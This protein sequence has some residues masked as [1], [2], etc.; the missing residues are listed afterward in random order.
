VTVVLVL[1]VVGAALALWIP[2]LSFDYPLSVGLYEAEYRL[3]G[4]LDERYLYTVE[5]AGTYRMLY[6]GFDDPLVFNRT[7]APHIELIGIEPP[8][9]Y[10][11]YA[12]DTSGEVRVFGGD[13]PGV[14]AFVIARAEPNEVGVVETGYFNRGSYEARYRF[15]IRPPIEYDDTLVHVNLMLA[16]EHV[17]YRSIRIVLPSQGVREV[18]AYPPTLV[19]SRENDRIVI[20]GSA[21]E[22]E[23]VAVELLLDRPMLDQVA[24]FPRPIDDIEG[25]T[26]NASLFYNLPYQVA[27]GLYWIGILFVLAVP[28]L[29]VLVHRRHGRERPFTVP[30]FLSTVPNRQ[31]K[32]WEVNL[33]YT[34]DATTSDENG[35]YATVLDLHRRGIIRIEEIEG[36]DDVLI[37]LTS[38]TP[39][40]GYEAEVVSFLRSIANGDGVVDTRDLSG[41]RERAKH[42]SALE[43]T[44]IRNLGAYRALA[45][46]TD[47][48]VVAAHVVPGRVHLL[49][50][51]IA[52]IVLACISFL[53]L[54]LFPGV[55]VRFVGPVLLSALG[56]G[57]SLIAVAFPSTLFGHWKDDA[58]RERLEWEAFA[59]FLS[60]LALIRQYSPAD[61][62][63]WGEW[64]VYGTALGVGDRVARAMRELNVRLPDEVAVPTHL[65]SAFVPMLFFTPPS[66]GG[67]GGGG[68]SGGRG[69]G[70][71]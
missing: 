41:L 56:V 67:S 71:A 35:F 37:H 34:G 59:R 70:A 63:M 27:Q 60:D 25:K 47:P 54:F 57:Q 44:M 33:L 62:S 21:G 1:G 12:R 39:D 15:I 32:P 40:D 26:R 14:Q 49:P 20:T 29:L 36:G 53:S 38:A 13:D 7:G 30:E 9:G 19:Q 51:V 28:F 8:P 50:I 66:S 10:P 52:A 65:Q 48:S 2:T 22:D 23:T 55:S 18:L 16:R 5:D 69:G 3:N 31:R 4:T 11:A 45:S 68:G 43:S 42:D 58:Y 64:L 61:L 6:R 24:G 46:H 17:P